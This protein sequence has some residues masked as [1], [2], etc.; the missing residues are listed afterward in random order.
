M[1]GEGREKKE[2]MKKKKEPV[3][4]CRGERRSRVITIPVT[5]TT[6]VCAMILDFLSSRVRLFPWGSWE[7]IG[8]PPLS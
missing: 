7:G 6:A 8:Q 3:R 5:T 1:K 2:K 4:F